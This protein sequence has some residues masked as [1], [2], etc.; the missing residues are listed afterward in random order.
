MSIDKKIIGLVVVVAVGAGY[1]YRNMSSQEAPAAP[2]MMADA[3]GGVV[4]PDDHPLHGNII[5]GYDYRDAKT[6]AMQDDDFENPAFLAVDQGEAAWSTVDGEAGKSCASCH[7]DDASSV[8]TV[9]STYP[10]FNEASGKLINIEQQINACRTDNMKAAPYKWESPDMLGMTAY[11]K[12]QGRSELVNVKI[13]GPAAPFFEKGKEFYYARRGQLDM[14]CAHC[15]EDNYGNN[16]RAD[17]LSQGQSNGFPTYRMKW[18][19]VGSL[20]RRF[21]GCNK[22]IRATSLAYGADDYVNLELYLAWRGQ[23]L[24]VEGPSVRN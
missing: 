15:H 23:G 11:L 18:Q 6:Q 21:R 12:S 16:I 17:L 3:T 2:E 13:D 10:V 22:N 1:M 5:S 14:S 4:I 7:G 9:A 20:H 8:K 24:P 19:G